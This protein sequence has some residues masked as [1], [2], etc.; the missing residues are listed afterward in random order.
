MN[1]VL[2]YR[3]ILCVPCNLTGLTT[4]ISRRYTVTDRNNHPARHTVAVG[5]LPGPGP[6]EHLLGRRQDFIGPRPGQNIRPHL[7][8]LRPLGVL[9]EGDAGHPEDAGLL[10]DAAGVGQDEAGI[11]LEL[12]EFE[13]PN[14]VHDGDPV[15]R[16]PEL[17]DH[18][19]GTRVHRE[20]N[21]ERVFAVD[22]PKPRDDVLQGIG[23]VDVLLPVGGDEEV[24][25]RLQPKCFENVC[26]PL[27]DL[28][29][30]EDG[31]N[32][33]VA[34]YADLAP[35]D[36]L[37]LEVAP[38]GLRGGEEI[39][40]DVVRN[41]PVDLFGHRPVEAP[42]AS[43]DVA[44]PDM[45]LC[46]SK[47]PGHDGV[48]VPLDEDDLRLLLDENLLD[49]GQDLSGLLGMS[50]GPDVEVVLRLRK[51]EILEERPV[52]L[53]GVVLPRVED[54]VVEVSCFAFPD[55]RGH[56]DDLRPRSKHNCNHL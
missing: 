28:P 55:D 40:G 21:G 45:E 54:E 22:R 25:L 8:R 52:H 43:L 39:V 27:R 6:G 24:A 36:P 38:C 12:Q 49:A 11:G 7:D 17:L 33:G 15:Q 34:G 20:D 23:V 1:S 47:G 18:L 30:L 10:L 4:I 42:E 2:S 19:P 29:V 44:D 37:I 3:G 9:P 48:G 32:D 16:N 35:L 26:P 31:V 50:S 13:E 51:F 56:L 46:G 14:G 41:H 53:V 5:V